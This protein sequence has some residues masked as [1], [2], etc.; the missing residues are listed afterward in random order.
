MVSGR[1]QKLDEWWK[2][3]TADEREQAKSAAKAGKADK[4]TAKSLLR[5]TVPLAADE[6]DAL[7]TDGT[8]PTDVSSYIM[9][10]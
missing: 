6:R 9:R 7:E 10:H 5:S 1:D 2:G 3:L 8:L 4:K